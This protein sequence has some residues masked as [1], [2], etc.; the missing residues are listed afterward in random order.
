MHAALEKR[1]RRLRAG[2]LY[3]EATASAQ[4]SALEAMVAVGA[5]IRAMLAERGVDPG[6]VA[7]LRRVDE[8]AAELAALPPRADRH[9]D[10]APAGADVVA[11]REV[12]EFVR[13]L[14]RLA[15][16][17]YADGERP[18]PAHASLMQWHAWCLATP[19]PRCPAILSDPEVALYRTMLLGGEGARR[20]DGRNEAI[21]P[22]SR[23]SIGRSCG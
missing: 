12:E 11:G 6:E 20:C 13:Q 2:L 4:R 3:A 9:E 1:L 21:R 8:A 10:A 18:D 5:Q 19:A 17:H 16:V 7:A 14:V 23:R 22:C 15:L